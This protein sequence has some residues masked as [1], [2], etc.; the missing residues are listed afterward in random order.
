ML[1]RDNTSLNYEPK[2]SAYSFQTEA[3][4]FCLNQDYSAIFYEQGLGKTKIAV[5]LLLK[6]LSN[7]TVT[8]VTRRYKKRAIEKLGG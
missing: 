3:T 8:K 7:D 6:W 4:D 5:D 1:H 2:K